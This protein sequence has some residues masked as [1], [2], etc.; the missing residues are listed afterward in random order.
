MKL[1]IFFDDFF[2]YGYLLPGFNVGKKFLNDR[3]TANVYFKISFILKYKF[4][5]FQGKSIE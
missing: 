3:E 4:N 1:R 5:I 2:I